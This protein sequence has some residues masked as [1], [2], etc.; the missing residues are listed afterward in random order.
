M[1]ETNKP[2][3]HNKDNTMSQWSQYARAHARG[4]YSRVCIA[5]CVKKKTGTK[6]DRDQPEFIGIAGRNRVNKK[7]A[8]KSFR[9]IRANQLSRT[10]THQQ[11]PA[12][13]SRYS[14]ASC[15]KAVRALSD[16]AGI[17][18]EHRARN[19]AASLALAVLNRRQEV[20]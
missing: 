8:E 3:I 11:A 17:E 13:G 2:L 1:T 5:V 19:A 12:A 16:R 10:K 7:G 14:E 20:A 18:L 4:K 6:W 15:D 9:A